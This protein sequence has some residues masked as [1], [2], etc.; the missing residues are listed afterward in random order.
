MNW[1][2]LGRGPVAALGD[3][4][5]LAGDAEVL[6]DGVSQE[7]TP[8][9]HVHVF[10]SVSDLVH[11]DI[12]VD[13]GDA[14]ALEHPPEALKPFSP[15]ALPLLR[16]GLRHTD[17]EVGGGVVE[18]E[19]LL[20]LGRVFVGLYLIG[21]GLRLPQAPLERVQGVEVFHHEHIID[22]YLHEQAIGEPDRVV[23]VSHIR[24]HL[25]PMD[26]KRPQLHRDAQ[27]RFL[28]DEVALAL[29]LEIN[30]QEPPQGGVAH[31]MQRVRV[32]PEVQK[33]VLRKLLFVSVLIYPVELARRK[34]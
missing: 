27:G 25:H 34:G 30:L 8:V 18:E 1:R 7:C 19:A 10:H 22:R 26:R 15:E 23:R 28:N 12:A 29:E 9:H 5:N 31:L 3:T 33:R 14:V 13:G 32:G 16:G 20:E 11:R 21:Q 17:N 24:R 2:R 4:H 6:K